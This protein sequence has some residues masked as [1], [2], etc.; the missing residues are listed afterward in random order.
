MHILLG[1]FDWLTEWFTVAYLIYYRLIVLY[2]GPEFKFDFRCMHVTEYEPWNWK[3]QEGQ[4][5]HQDDGAGGTEWQAVVHV[6][7]L[8]IW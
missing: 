2:A 4:I 8:M 6:S 7:I 1:F 3:F 5:L